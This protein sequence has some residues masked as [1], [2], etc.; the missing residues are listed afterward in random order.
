MIEHLINFDVDND[1]EAIWEN[2]K[3]FIWNKEALYYKS[4]HHNAHTQIYKAHAHWTN[5]ATSDSS[6]GNDNNYT[7][8]MYFLDM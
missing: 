8:N 6:W 3:S 2:L 4:L 7:I 1:Q 5:T